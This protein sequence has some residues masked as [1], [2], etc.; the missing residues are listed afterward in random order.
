LAFNQVHV[1]SIRLTPAKLALSFAQRSSSA[2]GTNRQDPERIN[3]KLGW[4]WRW[5]WAR[6]TPRLAAASSRV[7]VT[8]GTGA[9]GWAFT[10]RAPRRLH[11]RPQVGRASVRASVVH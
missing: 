8:R 7:S 2:M 11:Q 6:E 5:K 1:T 9:M 10:T 4:T 3:F